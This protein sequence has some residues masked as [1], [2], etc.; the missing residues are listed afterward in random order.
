[1]HS[2][3]EGERVDV[4]TDREEKKKSLAHRRRFRDASAHMHANQWTDHG[5]QAV[6]GPLASV[7]IARKK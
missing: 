4:A 3:N 6:S 1:M 5:G 7:G 2:R